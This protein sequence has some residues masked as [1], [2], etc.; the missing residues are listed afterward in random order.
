MRTDHANPAPKGCTMTSMW[1]MARRAWSANGRCSQH[2]ATTCT[3]PA[4][5]AR[6]ARAPSTQPVC[7]EYAHAPCAICGIA[8]T[9]RC[10]DAEAGRINLLQHGA[11]GLRLDVRAQRRAQPAGEGPADVAVQAQGGVDVAP[12]GCRVAVALLH[13]G[14]AAQPSARQQ[15]EEVSQPTLGRRVDLLWVPRR[16]A[17]R[18]QDGLHA[19]C[20]QPLWRRP[21][22]AAFAPQRP[23]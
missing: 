11:P 8:P 21:W 22:E 15:G 13:L 17:V 7:E 5:S 23:Q 6:L 2:P 14:Q 20:A 3:F 9:G 1:S 4:P 12:E 16:G 10:E 18:H 19:L